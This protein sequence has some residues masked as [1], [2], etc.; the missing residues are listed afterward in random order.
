MR[1]DFLEVYDFFIKKYGIESQHIQ[2]IEEMSEL[3]MALCKLKRYQDCDNK[4][5]IVENIK[6]ELADVLNMIEQLIFYYGIEDIE[7]IRTD[8]IKRILEIEKKKIN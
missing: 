4:S 3:T 8:K 2:C 5:D 7:Q 1:E 6:E